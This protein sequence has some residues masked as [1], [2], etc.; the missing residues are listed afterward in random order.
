[1][2]NETLNELQKEVEMLDALLNN[3]QVGLSSWA[4]SFKE[5]VDKFKAIVKRLGM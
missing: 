2:L 5:R 4:M 3:R 1:M